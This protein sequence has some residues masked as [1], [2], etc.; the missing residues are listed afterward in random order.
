MVRKETFYFGQAYK[1][2]I[3]KSKNVIVAFKFLCIRFQNLIFVDGN[4]GDIRVVWG[5]FIVLTV[6]LASVFLVEDAFKQDPSMWL[7]G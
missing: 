5:Q 2:Y 7:S 3:N 1:R 6:Y 4:I